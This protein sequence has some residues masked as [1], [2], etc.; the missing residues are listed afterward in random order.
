MIG[1]PIIIENKKP[2]ASHASLLPSHYTKV[3]TV[4][5]HAC[6]T[7]GPREA[8]HDMKR[9]KIG[10]TIGSDHESFAHESINEKEASE[11]G[12]QEPTSTWGLDN[13]HLFHG[14]VNIE[15]IFV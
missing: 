15:V 12:W 7:C 10:T 5:N 11:A 4:A 1:M 8:T 3:T 6:G 14:F 9:D 2:K 13:V